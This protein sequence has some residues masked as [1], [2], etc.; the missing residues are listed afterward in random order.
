MKAVTNIMMVGV[1][2]FAVGCDFDFD[3]SKKAAE[4]ARQEAREEA[5]RQETAK[6]EAASRKEA[7]KEYAQ[8]KVTNFQKKVDELET[9]TRIATIDSEDLATTL[10]ACNEANEKAN[11]ETKILRLMKNEKV[12]EL[13]IK[14]LGSGFEAQSEAFIAKVREVRAQE[15]K[16]QAAKDQA[17]SDYKAKVAEAEES[18][19]VA[20][21]EYE[22]EIR[23]LQ[24]DITG[25]EAR[26]KKVKINELSM[27]PRRVK[28]SINN[29]QNLAQEKVDKE[30]LDIDN[31]ISQKRVEIARLRSKIDSLH[32]QNTTLAAMSTKERQL[33]IIE[34]SHQGKD[35]AVDIATKMNEDTIGKLSATIAKVKDASEKEA[36]LAAENLRKAKEC[37]LEIPL[38]ADNDI[39]RLKKTIDSL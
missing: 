29:V 14:Y 2:A 36:E 9:K 13:A 8:A 38:C 34:R 33:S 15:K 24:R 12:N 37:L 6:Q 4:E 11:F 39:Y 17:D 30:R 1:L 18:N 3:G 32:S 16:Y 28:D 26:R 22:K 25:L 10:K 19:S 21:A 27:A 7:L 20:V 31:Q 23:R 35:N 5:L